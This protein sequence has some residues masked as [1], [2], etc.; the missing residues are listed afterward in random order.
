MQA[1]E[2]PNIIQIAEV[3]GISGVMEEPGMIN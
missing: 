2:Q 3:D 1:G